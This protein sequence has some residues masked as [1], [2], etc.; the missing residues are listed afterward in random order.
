MTNIGKFIPLVLAT[1]LWGL[2]P[3]AVKIL[4]LQYSTATIIFFRST[5]M[6]FF[7]I[8]LMKL[9]NVS[10]LPKLSM[11]KWSILFLMGL[12]GTT[13]C[14]ISQYEGLRYAPVFHCVLFGATVPAITA[15]M[16]RIFLKERLSLL[17]WGGILLSFFGVLFML[18]KGAVLQLLTEPFNIGDILFFINELSWSAYIIASRYILKDLSILQVTTLS[19]FIGIITLI[20]YIL[21]MGGLN[22]VI[23]N[24]NSLFAYVF[25]VIFSGVLA[26]LAWNK[27]INMVG[28]KGAVF[29]NVTPFT[30]LIFGNLILD[31]LINSAD[32]IGLVAVSCGIYILMYQK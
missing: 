24:M 7:Y 8:I 32:L 19:N 28:T 1:F 11:K 27:G 26:M 16:A 17:Q 12:T 21:N 30:G 29:N 10:L 23:P 22:L 25:V 4:L 15:C 3:I 18:T 14:S 2:Q 5:A 31:E 9:Y 6:L 13:I 20:P